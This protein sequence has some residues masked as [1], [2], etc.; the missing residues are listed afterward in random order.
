MLPPYDLVNIDL[1]LLGELSGQEVLVRVRKAIP[2]GFSQSSLFL[3]AQ[4]E[5]E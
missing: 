5:L 4:F 1:N 2:P 3:A